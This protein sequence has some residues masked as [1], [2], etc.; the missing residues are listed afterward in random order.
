MS[1]GCV[2]VHIE[3]GCKHVRGLRLLWL[4]W[5]RARRL[6]LL[7]AVEMGEVS[8]IPQSDRHLVHVHQRRPRFACSSGTRHYGASRTPGI[9]RS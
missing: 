2:V 3:S 8:V 6:P 9:A 7:Q 1:A 4:C 5:E